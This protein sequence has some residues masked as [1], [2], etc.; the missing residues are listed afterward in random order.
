MSSIAG[1]HRDFAKFLRHVS[2]LPLSPHPSLLSRHPPLWTH[3]PLITTQPSCPLWL[4]RRGVN[5]TLSY[6]SSPIPFSAFLFSFPVLPKSNFLPLSHSPSHPPSLLS[7][8]PLLLPPHLP[9]PT[10]TPS[11]SPTTELLATT[12]DS[13]HVFEYTS[14]APLASSSFVGR[15]PNSGGTVLAQSRIIWGER[16]FHTPS[17]VC[18]KK[19]SNAAVSSNRKYRARAAVLL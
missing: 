4:T 11:K 6:S 17:V 9:T 10:P 18:R 14:N 19:P 2:H 15:Q 1:C 12:G 8:L 16:S 7:I 13:L 3:F 5:Y